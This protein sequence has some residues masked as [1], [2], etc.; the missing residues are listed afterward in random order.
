MM[1]FT[2]EVVNHER[3]F[4]H[5]DYG[6]TVCH[7]GNETQQWFTMEILFYVVGVIFSVMM[8]QC[9]MEIM[10]FMWLEVFI[11]DGT[12]YYGGYS[13][14]WRQCVLCGW[15]YLDMVVQ[16]TVEV[17]CLRWLE[18]F[19]YGGTVYYGGYSVPWRQCVLCGWKYLDMVVQC[20]VE[21][22]CLRWLEVFI[23]GGT[24]YYGGYSVPWRQ[25][26]LGV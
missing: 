6:G 23:Y 14:P 19:I 11:H 20:T 7:V 13:V 17:V 16:C 22:V 21:V 9:A 8:V 24:V 18:V 26:A 4:C 3:T 5:V 1:H 2:M 12:V 25:C 15:K 10:C